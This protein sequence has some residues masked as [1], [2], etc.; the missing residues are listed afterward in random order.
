MCGSFKSCSFHG[1]LDD[2]GGDAERW[3]SFLPQRNGSNR[4]VPNWPSR[5]RPIDFRLT[6]RDDRSAFLVECLPLL[7]SEGLRMGGFHNSQAVPR[8]LNDERI[9]IVTTDQA[10]VS[11][12]AGRNPE[13]LPVRCCCSWAL[14]QSSV[15]LEQSKCGQLGLQPSRESDAASDDPGH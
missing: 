3:L 12:L 8:P 15:A 5:E 10:L 7:I 4:L 14:G 6:T 2:L 11:F 9:A 1:L 13:S